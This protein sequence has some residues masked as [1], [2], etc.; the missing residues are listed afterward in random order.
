MAAM[1]R[2][3]VAGD[4]T[5]AAELDA[6][7]AALHRNLFIEANPIPIKWALERVG[8]IPGGIRLPLT[9]LSQAN[10]PAV[11]AALQGAGLI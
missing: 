2:A 9:R 11:E 6:P 10:Q 7:L 3:A 4:A 1:C 5:E 8:R